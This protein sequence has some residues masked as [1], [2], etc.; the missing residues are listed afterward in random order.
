MRFA[1]RASRRS[2]ATRITKTSRCLRKASTAFAIEVVVLVGA[3]GS[4]AGVVKIDGAIVTVFVGTGQAAQRVLRHRGLDRPLEGID[5]ADDQDGYVAV[6]TNLAQDALTILRGHG[7]E[8]PGGVGAKFGGHA[9]FAKNRA[10]F[11]VAC[12]DQ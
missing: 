9:E 11:F 7:L 1:G 8:G 2:V 6:P 3:V 4:R 12:D 5:R 10:G